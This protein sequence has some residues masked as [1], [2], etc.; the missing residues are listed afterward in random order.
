MHRTF[1]SVAAI[2][3]ISSGS[4]A[5]LFAGP[6]QFICGTATTLEADPLI[7]GETGFWSVVQG[8]ATF[9]NASS[10]TSFVSDLE[11]GEN[12]LMWTKITPNGASPDNVSIWC[13]NIA[14]PLANAGPDQVVVAPPSTAIMDA[15]P[16]IAPAICF[17][18]VIAGSGTIADVN[19]PNTT[20]A[21]LGIGPNVFQWS[22][23]NGPCGVSS[24]VIIVEATEV[25]GIEEAW[26]NGNAPYYDPVD[27][28]LVF[29]QQ[30][31][32][33]SITV[34]DQQGRM[35]AQLT[36]PAGAGAWDLSAIPSGIYVAQVLSA[37]GSAMLRFV[38]R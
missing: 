33:M 3:F 9:A 24:D 14:M 26:S 5:S 27:Q 22:C 38:V 6:D 29:S 8:N 20:V 1:I 28:R 2:L 7:T 32:A 23:D 34:F 17:W 36:T 30:S 11:F 25:I 35:V 4:M 16:P 13:Y 12:V 10:P 31:H 19:D 37:G 21:G 18:T 15:D